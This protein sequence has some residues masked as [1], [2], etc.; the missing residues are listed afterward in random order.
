MLYIYIGA[1][2]DVVSCAIMMEVLLILAQSR[3]PLKHTLIFLFNGAEENILQVTLPHVS[4]L[5]Y[6]PI[7]W[8]IC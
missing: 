1:S 4:L 2:D 7:L 8:T 3:T 5:P 6:L